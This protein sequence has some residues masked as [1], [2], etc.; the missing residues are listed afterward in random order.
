M[1]RA[2]PEPTSECLAMLLLYICETGDG[3][4]AARS[5]LFVRWFIS[6][7]QAGNYFFKS[8]EIVS[9]GERNFAAIILRTDNP[10]LKQII[11]DFDEMTSL[12][13][14]KPDE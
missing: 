14:D 1:G 7:A 11:S 12:L 4:Q 3:K 10:E 13:S 2:E 5:K 6:Y 9:E 8:T